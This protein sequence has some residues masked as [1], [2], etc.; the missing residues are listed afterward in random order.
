MVIKFFTKGKVPGM[1]LRTK[2]PAKTKWNEKLLAI[3]Q[4]LSIILNSDQL[5]F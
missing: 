3:S 1:K 2:N 4:M 5:M